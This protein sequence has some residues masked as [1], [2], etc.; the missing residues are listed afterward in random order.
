M[1]EGNQQPQKF[2]YKVNFTWQKKE[3]G[4]LSY[5]N[6]PPIEINTPPEFGGDPNIWTPEELFISSILSCHMTTFLYF[7]KKSGFKF[8]GYESQAE[9]SV[10]KTE[11]GLKFLNVVVIIKLYIYKEE[12]KDR[13]KFFLELGEKYCLISH[14]IKPEVKFCYQ[15]LY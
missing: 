7:C 12:D 14:S 5:E 8:K 13:A 3:R 15:I 10:E 11:H 2:I 1:Q 9:G 6:R 4:I